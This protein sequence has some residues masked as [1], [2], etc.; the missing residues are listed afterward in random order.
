LQEDFTF[1]S[2]SALCQS[3]HASIHSSR[4]VTCPEDASQPAVSICTIVAV[5]LL[6]MQAK[7]LKYTKHNKKIKRKENKKRQAPEMI[8]L[9]QNNKRRGPG[10]KCHARNYDA[11]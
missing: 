10:K 3:D 9:Q 8:L 7:G 6:S 4:C 11:Q 2:L 5:P 1:L